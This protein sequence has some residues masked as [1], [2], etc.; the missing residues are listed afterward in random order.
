MLA[1]CVVCRRP[2]HALLCVCRGFSCLFCQVSVPPHTHTA[3]IKRIIRLF[4]L[5]L[6]A[7]PLSLFAACQCQRASRRSRTA[8]I[9]Q[10][11][12]TWWPSRTSTRTPSSAA[13][14]RSPSRWLRSGAH[15]AAAAVAQSLR[16]APSLRSCARLAAP[17]ATVLMRARHYRRRRAAP[18]AAPT[19]S[20]AVCWANCLLS[21]PIQSTSIGTRCSSRSLPTRHL[22]RLLRA[23]AGSRRRPAAPSIRRAHRRARQGMVGQFRAG[24]S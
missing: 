23:E 5:S 24:S 12:G 22:P 8:A 19:T 6:C 2:R 4:P 20:C 9:G 15:A 21:S 16:M 1:V 7:A 18:G 10:G 3:F 13:S 14:S 11:T 17:C